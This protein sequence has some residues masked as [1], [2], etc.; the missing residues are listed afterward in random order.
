MNRN[1]IEELRKAAL[2]KGNHALVEIC[3]YALMGDK[4]ALDLCA[5]AQVK[6]QTPTLGDLL[7]PKRR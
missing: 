7:L 3:D 2:E 1:E 6:P 4:D 5:K